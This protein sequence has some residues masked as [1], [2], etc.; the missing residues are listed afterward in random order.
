MIDET[1]SSTATRRKM[2][3][4]KYLALA[5]LGLAAM[6]GFAP[7]AKADWIT[8]S[9][10][11]APAQPHWQYAPAYRPVVYY[12]PRPHFYAPRPYFAPRPVFVNYQRP[13]YPSRGH[14]RHHH[15]HGDWQD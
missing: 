1:Q 13:Y 15:H 12:A 10:S 14:R 6:M 8:V 11:T 5:A 3:K 4:K 9:Y 7:Q 2:M